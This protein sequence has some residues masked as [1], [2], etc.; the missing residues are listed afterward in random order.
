MD[1]FVVRLIP[2]GL[3]RTFSPF[4]AV[5]FLEMFKNLLNA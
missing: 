4:S 1:N 5:E 3:S 2:V